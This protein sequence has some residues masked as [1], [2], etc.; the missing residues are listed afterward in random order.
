MTQE[1]VS[2]RIH[3]VLKFSYNKPRVGSCSG[4]ILFRRILLNPVAQLN[5]TLPMN[6]NLSFRIVPAV[7]RLQLTMTPFSQADQEPASWR[8][9]S[10]AEFDDEKKGLD[11]QIVNDGVMGGLSKGN[12]A[13]TEAGTVKF[14][15]DLSLRNNGGFTT[16]RSGQVDLDLSN[17]L[18]LLLLVKGDGRTYDARLDSS[19][20]YRGR[21]VSFSGPFKTTKGEWQQVKIPFSDFKGGFRG[22]DL[23]DKILDPS[24]I[25]QIWILLGDKQEGPFDLEIDWIRTYGKGQGNI[26]GQKKAPAPPGDESEAQT[27]RIME[28]VVADGRFKI[29]KTALDTAGLTPFFQW[30]NP[31]T[32]FA[33]T[34]KA[35]SKLPKDVLD[36]L[37]QPEN[38]KKL[39]SILSH[40]VSAGASSLADALKAKEVKTIEGSP[41]KV[42]FSDGAVRVNGAKVLDADLRCADGMIH[43]IDTVLLPSE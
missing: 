30:D 18:G 11:W 2:Q 3:V 35:F 34:D 17:S 22:T 7:L 4:G 1:P 12:L 37:L 25:E 20:R 28:T 29:L 42:S 38:K 21:P 43:V 24:V 14:F 15:G 13:F 9:Q 40:H 8:G 23:P 31:L 26:T 41:I 32:V 39:I 5:R 19:A 6:Q 33:P 36:D 16:M 10:I 27:A